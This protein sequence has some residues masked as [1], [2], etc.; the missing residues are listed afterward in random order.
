MKEQQWYAIYSKP[1][2]EACAKDN[3]ERQDYEVY[4]PLIKRKKRSRDKWVDTVETLFP[5]YLFIRLTLFQDSFYSIR[6]TRGVS[7]IVQ[8]GNDPAQVPVTLIDKLKA[9]QSPGQDYIDPA[10]PLFS[11]GDEVTITDGPF[12]GISGI[13]QKTSGQERVIMLL[14]LLGRENRV[15]VKT[16]D[17]MLKSA[18]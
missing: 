6:S 3:L 12:K 5:R 8:F 11:K 9:S 16:N 18:P 14:N 13:V 17:V 2:Q 1:R 10:R 7:K 4:L 15:T